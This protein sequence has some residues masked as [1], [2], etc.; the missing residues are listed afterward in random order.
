VAFAALLVIAAIKDAQTKEI[1]KIIWIAIFMVAVLRVVSGQMTYISAVLGLIAAGLPLLAMA[2]F[3]R[4]SVGGGDIKLAAAAGLF[5][6]E[7]GAIFMIVS[8][9]LLFWIVMKILLKQG[10]VSPKDGV[11]LGPYVAVCSI[12][13]YISILI[14]G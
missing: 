14:G 8:A 1:P 5:L 6:G 10:K 11:A 9:T 2:Y 12:I 4:G 7:N 13:L 3:K